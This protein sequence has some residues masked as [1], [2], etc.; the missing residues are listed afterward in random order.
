MNSILKKDVQDI[1]SDDI[2]WE[3]LKNSSAMITG[4]IGMIV[5]YNI[6]VIS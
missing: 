1:I 2:N 5:N 4:A 6:T 3:I